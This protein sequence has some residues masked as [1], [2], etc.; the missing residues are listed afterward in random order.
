M[1]S[2]LQ[3]LRIVSPTSSMVVDRSKIR[4]ARKAIR[5]ETQSLQSSQH[6]ELLGLYFDDRKDQT[7]SQA[8]I[9][10]KF[11]R[12]TVL[13][14]HIVLLL[15]AGSKYYIGHF[16]A[17]TALAIKTDLFEFLVKKKNPISGI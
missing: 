16:T 3:D 10:E 12:K 17:S 6:L 9:G 2:T 7:I 5:T 4:R 15:E 13:E 8:K 14:E 11:V 1:S